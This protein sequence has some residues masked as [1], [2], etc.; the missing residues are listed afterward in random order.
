VTD[1]TRNT[2]ATCHHYRAGWCANARQAQL[3]NTN[4]RAEIGR[5]LAETPQNCNGY[6]GKKQNGNG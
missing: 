4:G 6:K 2:C 3:T 1:D 5:T